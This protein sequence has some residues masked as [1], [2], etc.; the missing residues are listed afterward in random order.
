MNDTLTLE[1]DLRRE[2]DVL[3]ATFNQGQR[4]NSITPQLLSDLETVLSL[5]QGD[6]TIKCLVLAGSERAFSV[7]LD[8]DLLTRAF[9]EPEY[10]ESVL[11]RLAGICSGI[12]QLET[13]VVAVV[14]G[15][16]RAGGFEILLA[17]DVVLMSE[18]ARIGDV[19]SAFAVAPGGGSSFRLPRIVG[20]ARAKEIFFSGRWI[21]ATEAVQLGL[22]LEAFS[23]DKQ[24]QTVDNCLSWITDK[25]RACLGTIKQQMNATVN[26]SGDAAAEAERR[27]F[28]QYVTPVDSDAQEGFRASMENRE[29]RWARSRATTTDEKDKR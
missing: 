24:K 16:A 9:A 14:S 7:G 26:L 11:V 2:D 1:I 29:P 12:E 17:C 20:T 6:P 10:F 19:H 22:A 15:L 8:L 18:T 21:D 4:L 3:Y 13:P 5:V 28:L 27:L 25:S 23:P